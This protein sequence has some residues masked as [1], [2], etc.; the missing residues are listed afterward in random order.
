MTALRTFPATDRLL[1]AALVVLTAATI[2][3]A[4][5]AH[6]FCRIFC[7]HGMP[8]IETEICAGRG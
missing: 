6:A 5:N 3:L 1:A 7:I 8:A 4:T 2:L